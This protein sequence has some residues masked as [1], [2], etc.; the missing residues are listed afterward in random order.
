M[1]FALDRDVVDKTGLAGAYDLHLETTLDEL[2]RFNS[3]LNRM[4]Q[5]PESSVPEAPRGS[6]FTA[7]RRIGLELK[8]STRLATAIVIDDV[9]MPEGN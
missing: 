9:K 1:S 5:A 3:R 8:P 4:P 6:I 7:L 2:S